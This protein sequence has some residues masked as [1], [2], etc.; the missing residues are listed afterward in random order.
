MEFGPCMCFFFFKQKSLSFGPFSFFI[1]LAPPH[2]ETRHDLNNLYHFTFFVWMKKWN[3]M[4]HWL[5]TYHFLI[6]WNSKKQAAEFKQNYKSKRRFHI[7]WWNWEDTTSNSISSSGMP[8]VFIFFHLILWY[9]L[10]SG[11]RGQ[12]S[13]IVLFSKTLVWNCFNSENWS[14][15]V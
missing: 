5:Q 6:L 11:C 13:I 8:F 14:F 4:P 7:C 9:L 3:L 2:E 15:T 12:L 1:F 10:S